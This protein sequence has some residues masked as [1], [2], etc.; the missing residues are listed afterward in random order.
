MSY[1][2]DELL[3]EYVDLLPLLRNRTVRKHQFLFN[4]ACGKISDTRQEIVGKMDK[5]D[6]PKK[7]V[8]LPAEQPEK[9]VVTKHVPVMLNHEEQDLLRVKENGRCPNKVEVVVSVR[10][11]TNIGLLQAKLFVEHCMGLMGVY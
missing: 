5:G 9:E 3:N 1:K 6:E 2:N 7:V 11:R 4:A 10:N 8:Y